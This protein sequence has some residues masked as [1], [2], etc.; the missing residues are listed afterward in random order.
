MEVLIALAVVT[1]ALAGGIH[2][3]GSQVEQMTYVRDKTFAHWVALNRIAELR[4]LSAW[5]D[6]DES[7][8]D[9]EMAGRK[10]YWRQK[11]SQ[12]TD[13]DMRQVEIAVA[14]EEDDDAD[15]VVTVTGFLTSPRVRSAQPGQ[16]LQ[17]PEPGLEGGV[18]Q[19]EG[20]ETI[21]GAEQPGGVEQR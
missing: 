9:V 13:E 15:P 1:I 8:G 3:M 14:L 6:V 4:I 10:W 2:A 19:P 11:V 20:T 7:E 18:A 17:P 21:E 16:P 12:L 5:P